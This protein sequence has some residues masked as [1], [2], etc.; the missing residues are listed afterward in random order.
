MQEN[1]GNNVPTQKQLFEKLI[2]DID[3]LA[4]FTGWSKPNIRVKVHRGQIPARRLT[5][6]LHFIPSEIM[7]CFKNS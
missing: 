4:A 6:R 5:R 7:D 3:D 1:N 2:W